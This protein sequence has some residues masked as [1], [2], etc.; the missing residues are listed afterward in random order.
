MK[1]PHLAPLSRQAIVLLKLIQRLC[2][3][4]QELVFPSDHN[5]CKP[6]SQNTLNKALR[7]IGYDTQKDV[8]D[9]GFRIMACSVLVESGLWSSDAVERQMSHQERKRVR[10]AYIHKAQH[11][12]ERREMMRWWADYLDAN[13]HYYVVP[14]GLGGKQHGPLMP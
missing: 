9:H 11:L 6:M 4:G 10:A 14:M 2:R 3:E 5:Y 1:T 13:R 12:E 8:R 7:V